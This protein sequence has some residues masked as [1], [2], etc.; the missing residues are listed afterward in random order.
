M[1][2]SGTFSRICSLSCL[3]GV[4]SGVDCGCSWRSLECSSG[5]GPRAFL[6]PTTSHPHGSNIQQLQ[7]EIKEISRK[8]LKISWNFL[9][10]RL[11]L[12]NVLLAPALRLLS[13]L[14]L[15]NVLQDVVLAVLFAFCFVR[16]NL[17]S[18]FL[19]SLNVITQV[20]F[21]FCLFTFQVFGLLWII[22]LF[23]LQIVILDHSVGTSFYLFLSFL[24]L[25]YKTICF[26]QW[27]ERLAMIANVSHFQDWPSNWLLVHG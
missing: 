13:S 20:P 12:Q 1:L 9:V 16:S 15:V 5:E 23:L 4:T 19:Q 3:A 18:K 26:C 27:S 14:S 25:L 10:T 17:T 8:R 11:T 2:K 7:A 21:L 24:S 22:S 6:S